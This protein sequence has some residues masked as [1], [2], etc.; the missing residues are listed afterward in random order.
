[1]IYNN[2]IELINAIKINQKS[3]DFNHMLLYY[4]IIHIKTDSESVTLTDTIYHAFNLTSI[5]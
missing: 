4:Q 5:V 3:C 1:M 2:L